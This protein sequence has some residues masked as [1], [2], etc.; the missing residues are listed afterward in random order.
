MSSES[1]PMMYEFDLVTDE[2]KGSRPAGKRP[3][4]DAIT[5]SGTATPDIP[6]PEKDGYKQVGFQTV[7]QANI[8]LQIL[9][10]QARVRREHGTT[11]LIIVRLWVKT[12]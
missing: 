12:E 5:V 11:L 4:G 8:R 1:W 6:G 10:Y 9:R 2:Y 7:Q 3:N